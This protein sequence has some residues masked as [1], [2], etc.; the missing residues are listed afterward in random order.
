MSYKISEEKEL[1][2]FLSTMEEASKHVRFLLFI[3][4]IT[5]IYV[6]FA[7]YT[8]DWQSETLVLPIIEAEIS[9]RWFFAISPVFILFNYVYMH[10]FLKDMIKRGEMY[11]KLDFETTFVDKKF[12]TFPW[13]LPTEDLDRN[14]E[15]RTLA[16]KFIYFCIDVIFWW[17][18]PAVLLVILLA[19]NFQSDITAL[20]PYTCF[21]LSI[22]HY[23]MNSRFEK[24]NYK[25]FL[26]AY[27]SIF[28]LF[29][30]MAAVPSIPQFF[31]LEAIDRTTFPGIMRL[32]VKTYFLIYF[33]IF[34]IPKTWKSDKSTLKKSLWIAFYILGI[35]FFATGDFNVKID[36]G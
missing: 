15:T 16:R 2:Y 20:V 33:T 26:M 22:L 3:L 4:L 28:L 14:P 5:S 29:L 27:M 35:I 36:R 24:S 25:K 8:G 21:F 6:D 11:A 23:V 9:R 34:A 10:L 12:L 7:A 1:D 30:T 18:G 31:G 32:F 19:Y 13:I 17:Y